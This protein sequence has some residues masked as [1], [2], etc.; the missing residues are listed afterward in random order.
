MASRRADIVLG[1]RRPPWQQALFTETPEASIVPDDDVIDNLHTGDIT[2]LRELP[3]QHDI[4][5]ARRRI[6]ARVVVCVMCR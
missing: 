1:A 4:C 6:A 2:D 3:R 5:V